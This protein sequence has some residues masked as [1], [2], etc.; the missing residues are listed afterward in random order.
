MRIPGEGP[1]N[2]G[3]IKSTRMEA[4][5]GKTTGIT[6]GAIKN[7]RIMEQ[8][9]GKIIRTE[10]DAQNFK[11]AEQRD[12][13]IKTTGEE[14]KISTAMII[15]GPIKP[16]TGS[17]KTRIMRQGDEITTLVIREELPDIK[18]TRKKLQIALLDPQ[19]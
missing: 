18:S 10:E 5:E 1:V 16:L 7:L 19:I 14:D 9:D 2:T 6:R 15:I 17:E 11:I 12:K 13:N 3:V 4:E 8:P